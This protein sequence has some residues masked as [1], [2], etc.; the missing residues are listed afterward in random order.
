VLGLGSGSS[1][2]KVLVVLELKIVLRIF[3]ADLFRE[4]NKISNDDYCISVSV[5]GSLE[6]RLSKRR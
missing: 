5:A 4:L 3:L 1:T 2:R 6:S